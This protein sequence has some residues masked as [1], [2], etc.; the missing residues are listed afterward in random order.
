M[1][2]LRIAIIF[3]A[4]SLAWI[5]LSD[6]VVFLMLDDLA[7]IQRAQT[8]KGWAF[9]VVTSLI[10]YFLAKRLQSALVREIDNKKR[11]LVQ[12]RRKAYTDYL[13]NLPNRRMGLRK[14]RQLVHQHRPFS[15]FF[16][17]L[18]NFKQINDSLG[19]ELGDQVIASIANSLGEQMGAQQYLIRHGGDEFLVILEDL[20]DAD[21]VSA[22]ADR[23]MQVFALPVVQGEL[24]LRVTASIG[25]AQF[26]R[27]GESVGMLMRSAHL[28]LHYSK[29]Y[30]NCFRL[31]HDTM[32]QAVSYRF[33]LDQRLR[34]AMVD[35]EFQVYYQ[36]IFDPSDGRITGA[37]ALL[38]W[39]SPEGFISPAEFIPVAESGGH[40]RALGAMVLRRACED[41]HSLSQMLGRPLSISINVSP[42]QFVDGH[43]FN[44]LSEVLRD[45]GISPSQVV[46]EITEG[47]FLNQVIETG[48][49]LV[50]LVAMGVQLSMDDF[51][52]GYSS[53]SYLRKHPFTY[54]KIDQL[55][56]QGM[57]D[58]DQ[59]LA[60]VEASIAMGKAL[61]IKTVAE[62]VETRE[63]LAL[64]RRLNVD[65]VQGFYLARPMPLA[66]YQAKLEAEHG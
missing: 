20:I 42:M 15:L 26:P 17:D 25:I 37:E 56:V 63:Q 11:H 3:L 58:S 64:L 45:I 44:D 12:L 18:D 51:G 29:K 38:R 30:K 13:T 36:P 39:P 48:E 52:Q 50:Q 16:I 61:N 33:D 4:F 47:V 62:G 59:D 57:E 66:E 27:D 9:V 7:L 6:E 21:K 5:L 41:C 23:L 14:L 19:H 31:Y 43:I 60:L 22:L 10:I 55:F 65:F 2:P 28:A 24:S 49:A 34:Q 54:L 32:S 40:I 8:I 35:G 46:L 1:T 53:L